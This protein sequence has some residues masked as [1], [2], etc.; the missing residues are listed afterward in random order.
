[1]A[2]GFIAGHTP[3]LALSVVYSKVGLTLSI[4]DLS[5]LLI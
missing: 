3:A 2:L 5:Y 4:D 1:M